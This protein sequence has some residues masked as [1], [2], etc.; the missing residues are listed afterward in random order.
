[1]RHLQIIQLEI[2]LLRLQQWKTVANHRE[3]VFSLFLLYNTDL[4][5]FHT[6]KRRSAIKQ[7]E[8]ML[9]W[10]GC[11]RVKCAEMHFQSP[12]NDSF[13]AE[14]TSPQARIS[15]LVSTI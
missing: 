11:L 7:A 1:M 2:T 10:K 15:L 8:R 6:I 12:V 9:H 4:L 14:R 5:V 3:L 13:N